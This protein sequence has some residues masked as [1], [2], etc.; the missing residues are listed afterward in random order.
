MPP[1]SVAVSPIARD[2]SSEPLELTN[3]DPST[4]DDAPRT[5][6]SHVA[7]ELIEQHAVLDEELLAQEDFVLVEGE[8]HVNALLVVLVEDP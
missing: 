1:C 7:D 4:E 3:G 2:D 5:D 6:G 8:G